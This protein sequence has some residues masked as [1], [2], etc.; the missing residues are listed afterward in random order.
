MVV[1]VGSNSSLAVSDIHIADPNTTPTIADTKNPLT[2]RT[3]LIPKSTGSCPVFD[4]S[5]AV[6]ITFLIFGKIVVGT[7]INVVAVYHKT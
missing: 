4:I 3:I 7:F 1:I 2:T 5:T 6:T